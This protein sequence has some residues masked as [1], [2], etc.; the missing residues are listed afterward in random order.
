MSLLRIE[1]KGED[2]KIL[3]IFG[4]I[5]GLVGLIL[6][7]TSG[8]LFNHTKNFL[9]N[10]LVTQGTVF[11]VVLRRTSGTGTSSTRVGSGV[12]CPLFRFKT[13]TGE[14]IEIESSF[15]SNPPSYA[16]GDKITVRYQPENPYGAKID[17]FFHICLPVM[18]TGGL[19]FL[20]FIIGTVMWGVV[21]SSSRKD[22]W[23]QQ[24]GVVITT[25]L[26][27]VEQN[28][29]VSSGGRHPYQIFSQWTDPGTST[30]YVFKSKNIWFN[31]QDFIPGKEIQVRMDQNNPKKY[32]MDTSF[33]PESAD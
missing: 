28:R 9:A 22:K 20:F 14:T 27:S 18:I 16:I 17:S 23:L 10:S 21:I 2:M 26:Q 25:E 15:G 12:Y 6:L 32:L 24:H 13:N 7:L 29:S 11:D 5:F 3:K 4:M 33:L 19:G 31:P 1:F 8:F 30:V